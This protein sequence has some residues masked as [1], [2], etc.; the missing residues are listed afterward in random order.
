MFYSFGKSK[1]RADCAYKRVGGGC[2]DNFSLLYR[3][4]SLQ[5][6]PGDG[7]IKTEITASE[8]Q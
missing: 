8:D 7:S 5:L 3:F 1:A 2:L 6:S 4:C